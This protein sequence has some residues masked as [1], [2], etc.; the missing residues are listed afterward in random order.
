MGE[1][2]TNEKEFK[3]IEEVKTNKK[4]FKKTCFTT[5]LKTKHSCLSCDLDISCENFDCHLDL[6]EYFV[7]LPKTA[8]LKRRF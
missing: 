3:K 6:N 2:E 4:E 8:L 5:N 7:F 1:Y